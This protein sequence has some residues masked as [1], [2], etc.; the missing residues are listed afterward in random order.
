MP[1]KTNRKQ[2]KD[3]GEERVRFTVHLTDIIVIVRRKKCCVPGICRAMSALSELFY[4]TCG[5]RYCF[6]LCFRPW[7]RPRKPTQMICSDMRLK[8]SSMAISPGQFATTAKC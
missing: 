7:A 1:A 4:E 6:L 5:R 8:S 2:D 3:T